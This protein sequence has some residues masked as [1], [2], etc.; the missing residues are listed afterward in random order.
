MRRVKITY[1]EYN[2][3][4]TQEKE[5]ETLE[6]RERKGLIVSTRFAEDGHIVV[7][8]RA[9]PLLGRLIA[10]AMRMID[11]LADYDPT[12]VLKDSND[13]PRT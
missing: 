7:G 6:V 10:G 3:T 4:Y 12:P 13:R 5:A 8:P 1:D 11:R 9:V 2:A